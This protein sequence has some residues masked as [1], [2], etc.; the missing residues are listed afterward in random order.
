MIKQVFGDRVLIKPDK[1]EEKTSGGIILPDSS[2]KDRP[3]G[4][5]I[6]IGEGRLLP[7]GEYSGMKLKEGMHVAYEQYAGQTIAIDGE[8]YVLIKSSSVTMEL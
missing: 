3:E 4:T 6:M 5:I 2:R 1:K 8:L 7:N